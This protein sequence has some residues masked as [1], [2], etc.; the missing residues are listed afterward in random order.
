MSPLTIWFAELIIRRLIVD[1]LGDTMTF[2]ERL[3]NLQESRGL[4][5]KDVYS[6][7]GISRIAYYRYERGERMP[8]YELLLALADFFNVSVDYLM[9]RTDN[10]AINR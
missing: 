1:H 9:C 3:T 5:K 6:A 7:C 10:P 2:S 8:T 4:S